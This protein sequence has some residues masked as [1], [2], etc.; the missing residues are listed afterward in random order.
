MNSARGGH[1]TA[2]FNTERGDR[3]E[4]S[5]PWLPTEKKSGEGWD[6]KKSLGDG[7][8]K[9]NQH[10]RREGGKILKRYGCI[11]NCICLNNRFEPQKIK[12]WT[13]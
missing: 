7:G 8:R 12:T 4:L 5:W 1:K 9:K 11:S 13:G 6:G 10:G 3:S 2:N